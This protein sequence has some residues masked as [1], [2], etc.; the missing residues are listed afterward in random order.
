MK[1]RICPVASHGPTFRA[2]R[3]LCQSF[4]LSDYKAIHCIMNAWLCSCTI[5]RLGVRFFLWLPFA[6]N[7]T[8]WPSILYSCVWGTHTIG[9]HSEDSRHALL[10]SY[11]NEFPNASFKTGIVPKESLVLKHIGALQKTLST[12][13]AP[14]SD[15][16]QERARARSRYEG[17]TEQILP[18]ELRTWRVLCKKLKA[19]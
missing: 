17:I 12:F 4:A 2:A 19:K 5:G 16:F 1:F 14:K 11:T 9:V 10:G 3:T 8:V 13:R 18:L 6:E 7:W 15:L